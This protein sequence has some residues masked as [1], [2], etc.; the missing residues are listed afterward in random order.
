MKRFYYDEKSFYLDGKKFLLH[1]G[2]MHYFRIPKEYW[3]DRLL[4][5]KECGLTC[6]ETYIPWN[7]H[8]PEEGKFV[9]GGDIDLAGYIEQ[10]A[11]LGLY[12]IVRPGPYI[13]AEWEAGGFPHWLKRYER[14][15]VRTHE[16][17][18]LEKITPY[19]RKVCEII[20][21]YLIENGGNVL[22]VQIENEFG[23]FDRDVEY[24]TYIKELYEKTIPEAML[25]TADGEW[26]EALENGTLPDV[27]VCG[28]FGSQI[29]GKMQYIKDFRPNQPYVCMEFWC[30]WFD[31]WGEPHHTRSTQEKMECFEAFIRNDY[32]FNVYMFHGGTNFGFTNGAN[33]ASENYFPT[34]TSYDYDALL[35]ECGDRTECY[36]ALRNLLASVKEVPPITA[37]E[38]PKRA[39]GKVSFNAYLPLSSA[40]ESIGKT[41]VA[42]MPLSFAKTG[43]AHG[44]A[45]YET[46]GEGKEFSL[47]VH[48]Y[49]V[50]YIGGKQV[51]T[52]LRINE[53]NKT[54]SVPATKE[55][56]GVL[57]E[58]CGRCNH[59]NYEP[60]KA[61]DDKGVV[62]AKGAPKGWKTTSLP[63][64]DLENLSFT[65][66]PETPEKQSAFYKGSFLVDTPC[67]TFLRLDGF[68]KGIAFVNGHNLGRYW[69]IGPQKTLYVPAPWLKA[70]E[71][72]LIIFDANGA[73]SYDAELIAEHI[74]G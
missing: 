20:R 65:K 68:E 36:Y 3:Y 34:T 60:K 26:R 47:T 11:K 51:K 59:G 74:L 28:N 6:V 64:N 44:Y 53:K 52:A 24:L 72:E 70:G 2:A 58:N 33:Y 29:E 32:G 37:T 19:L 18:Y 63:M 1:S 12:V 30:G 54:L 4:K 25:F 16:P 15:E 8:E 14:L 7:L 45:Y 55:K 10:A 17:T 42:E 61:F 43:Q 38:T 9:F 39:Y 56:I 5:L 73:T 40:M 13:C 57:V 35:T 67:D 50:L 31:H 62:G 66:L 46:V 27:L 69:R 41:R 49:A 21:P 22:M 71:N 23:S 48:D